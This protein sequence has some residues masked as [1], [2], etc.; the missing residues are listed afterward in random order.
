MFDNVQ[1]WEMTFE[2]LSDSLRCH[3]VYFFNL[4]AFHFISKLLLFPF[5]KYPRDNEALTLFLY[6]KDFNNNLLRFL[7]LRFLVSWL[8]CEDVPFDLV[9]LFS[10]LFVI[11]AFLYQITILA[12]DLS[13]FN[14]FSHF[15]KVF[16]F[17]LIIFSKNLIIFPNQ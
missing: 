16:N 8:I 2:T 15:F 6:S 12:D 9:F 13:F 3:L 5:H 17:H 11:T 1:C 4:L 14:H 7:I 10:F